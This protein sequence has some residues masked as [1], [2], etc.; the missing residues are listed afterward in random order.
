M[1]SIGALAAKITLDTT[2]F[3]EGLVLSKREMAQAR[4]IQDELSGSVGKYRQALAGLNKLR[5]GGALND[6]EHSHAVSKLRQEYVSTLPIVGR[7]SGMMDPLSGGL[8]AASA[9]FAVLTAAV[10]AAGAIVANRIDAID[11]LADSAERLGISASS[12]SRLRGAAF[13]GDVDPQTIDAALQKMLVNLGKGDEAF[14]KLNLNVDQLRQMDAAQV[15][16]AIA[17]EIAKLPSKAERLAMISEI[18]GKGN[19]EMIGMIERFG[20]L[21]AAARESGAVVSD[22]LAAEVGRADEALKQMQLA[23]EG[24]AN[25]LTQKIAPAVVV[26]ANALTELAKNT[27]MAKEA[28][29]FVATMW[30]PP[31]ASDLAKQGLAGLGDGPG[32]IGRNPT[33]AGG[34]SGLL[35]AMLADKDLEQRADRIGSALGQL[36]EQAAMLGMD[37][38]E[39]AAFRI[40]ELGGT[41]AQQQEAAWLASQIA[42]HGKLLELEKQR[43][44]ERRR[45]FA[46]NEREAQA[47]LR[48]LESPRAKAEREFREKVGALDA[49]GMLTPERFAMLARAGAGNFVRGLGEAPFGAPTAVKGSAAA[50]TAIEQARNANKQTELMEKMERHLMHMAERPALT[51]EVI[52]E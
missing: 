22:S 7:F 44:E 48:E 30:L 35:G 13:L 18:F 51:V 15:F 29:A 3:T 39:Q 4:Q 43:A 16:A 47:V 38:G 24:L 33:A 1:P 36:R 52:G 6:R 11:Q 8:A 5:A 45:R 32:K 19:V 20:D 17:G 46:E 14:A 40:A 49:A 10:T 9:G 41:Q 21:D 50:R 28:A 12:L 25:V 31:G 34:A 37:K 2:E 27:D 42:G 23:G 26:V